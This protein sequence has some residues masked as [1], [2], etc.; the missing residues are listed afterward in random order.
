[1][2]GE[3]SSSQYNHDFKE[4]IRSKVLLMGGLK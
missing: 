3:H 4:A 1:M 2:L